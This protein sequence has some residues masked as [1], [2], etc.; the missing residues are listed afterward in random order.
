MRDQMSLC[1]RRVLTAF[2]GCSALFVFGAGPVRGQTAQTPQAAAT[3][4]AS[5]AGQLQGSARRLSID[6]AVAMAL[7]QNVD[8]QVDRIDPQVQDYSVSVARSGWT[9]AF[10]SNV[11]TRH[12]TNPPTDIFG[13]D[14]TAITDERLTTQT[15]V[16]QALPWGGASYTAAWVS[17]RVSTN[18]IFSSF[19][20]QLNNTISA[21]YTQPLLRNFRIDATR[22]R[23][24]ER[25]AAEI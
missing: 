14:S 21:N 22:Q 17:G 8:L 10:F 1:G 25:V 4:A 18:N 16:Q 5:A 15:G 6:E 11:T 2:V 20:P 13:G 23:S 9:P 24:H 19:N 12:Q 3:I 7:E